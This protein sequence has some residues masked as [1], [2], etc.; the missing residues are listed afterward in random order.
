MLSWEC[1]HAIPLRVRELIPEYQRVGSQLP[2]SFVVLSQ[3]SIFQSSI[4]E[5][6]NIDIEFTGPDLERLI[7]LGSEAFGRLLG[8]MP[9]AQ[10]LP[11]PSLDLGNPEVQVITHR[12]RAAELG[13]SNRGSRLYGQRSH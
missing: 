7:E 12:R 2:G 6:R 5:G 3:F 11:I 10:I 4:N 1:K 9:D 8:I 13:L